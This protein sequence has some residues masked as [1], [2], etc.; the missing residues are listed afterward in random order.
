MVVYFPPFKSKAFLARRQ[1]FKW[2]SYLLP[3]APDTLLTNDYCTEQANQYYEWILFFTG[4][5]LPAGMELIS[6]TVVYTVL[7]FETEIISVLITHQCF[8]HCWEVLAQHTAFSFSL[9][10]LPQRVSWRCTRNWLEI[11]QSK[12]HYAQLHEIMERRRNIYCFHPFK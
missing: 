8:G 9:L 10:C 12:W 2:M 6:F 1:S 3:S 5:L 7:H 11:F 4:S